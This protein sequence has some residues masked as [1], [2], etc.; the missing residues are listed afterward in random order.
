[1]YCLKA[2]RE[3]KKSNSTGNHLE[4]EMCLCLILCPLFLFVEYDYGRHKEQK[5]QVF[6]VLVHVMQ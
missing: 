3:E 4:V 2:R 6:D 1:M 5:G